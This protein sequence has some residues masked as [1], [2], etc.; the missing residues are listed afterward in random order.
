MANEVIFTLKMEPQLLAEFMAEAEVD[1]RPAS[2]IIRDLMFEFI[3]RQREV[4]KYDEFLK[5][6]V[7]T[8]IASMHAG[9]GISNEAVEKLFSKRRHVAENR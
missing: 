1:H 9:M 3:Q 5:E 6:K 4:R 7:A 2:Q 8:S